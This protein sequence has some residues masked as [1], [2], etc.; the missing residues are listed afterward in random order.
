M[1][2]GSASGGVS[3]PDTAAAA[4]GTPVPIWMRKAAA[5]RAGSAGTSAESGAQIFFKKNSAKQKI[6]PRKINKNL[7]MPKQIFTV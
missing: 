5:T 7:K 4:I 2:E 1:G 3:S 6:N